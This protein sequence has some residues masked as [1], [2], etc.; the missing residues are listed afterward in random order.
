[1]IFIKVLQCLQKE[2][3]LGYSKINTIVYSYN[4]V[5][6]KD[7]HFVEMEIESPAIEPPTKLRQATSGVVMAIEKALYCNG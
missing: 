2:I 5:E 3:K 6:V 1:M 7:K 4:Q